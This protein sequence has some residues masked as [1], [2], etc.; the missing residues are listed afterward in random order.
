MFG[1]RVRGPITAAP[2]ALSSGVAA[3]VPTS[4]AA[5]APSHH[6]A[7]HH[8][9]RTVDHGIPQHGGGDRDADNFGGP[10]DGDGNV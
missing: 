5:H 9:H 6:V 3:L 1:H 4:A 2:I 8:G 10:S 7:H